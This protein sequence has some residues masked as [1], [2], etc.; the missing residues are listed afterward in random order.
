IALRPK[1]FLEWTRR[2][3]A[4]APVPVDPK[5][6]GHAYHPEY[7][8]PVDPAHGWQ[9]QFNSRIERY[10][11]LIMDEPR[12]PCEPRFA[13]PKLRRLYRWHPDDGHRNQHEDR[14]E[15]QRQRNIYKRHGVPPSM[16]R[17]FSTK[18]T[19]LPHEKAFDQAI[20]S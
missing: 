7:G 19:L 6:T 1:T 16:D 11:P 2:S 20:S 8:S 3:G 10:V 13:L 14:G 15:N 4:E 17:L 12:H 9:W 18:G 5:L